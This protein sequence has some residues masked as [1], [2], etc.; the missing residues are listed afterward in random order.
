M[1]S[2]SGR[3]VRLRVR[4]GLSVK[5][6]ADK[7]RIGED[8]LDHWESGLTNPKPCVPY[9]IEKILDYESKYGCIDP[10]PTYYDNKK[11]IRE[12]MDSTGLTP[13]EFRKKF[14]ISREDVDKWHSGVIS[15]MTCVL[16]MIEMLIGY[17]EKY[18]DIPD[19]D[20]INDIE[21]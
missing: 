1:S 20:W 11:R 16:Y 12:V 9:M 10:V 14:K 13:M 18:G 5:T 7:F 8:V 15:P 2:T 6:F 17:E 19:P 4:T 3:V 21:I